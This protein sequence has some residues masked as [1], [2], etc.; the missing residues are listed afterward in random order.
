MAEASRSSTKP[1]TTATFLQQLDQKELEKKSEPPA[2]SLHTTLQQSAEKEAAATSS[3]EG[4]SDLDL[5]TLL[6]NFKDLCT[7]EQHSLISYLKKLEA[8]VVRT[9]LKMRVTQL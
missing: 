2:G 8:K 6:Q 3:M 4:L 5:Q 7:D 9:F 1:M